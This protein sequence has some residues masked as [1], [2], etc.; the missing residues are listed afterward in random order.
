M[1]IR[2]R[3]VTQAVQE[4]KADNTAPVVK[5]ELPLAENARAV[6]VALPTQACLLYTSRC[7]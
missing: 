4:A 1:C 2:D 6:E 7:V 5:V 3:A